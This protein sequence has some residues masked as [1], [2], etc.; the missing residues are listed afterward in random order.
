MTTTY[1]IL[2]KAQHHDIYPKLFKEI[3]GHDDPL[4]AP[5]VIA[6]ALEKETY[7][8][9]VSGYYRSRAIFYIQYS[10]ILPGLRTRGKEVRYFNN[11]LDLIE[12]RVFVTM[13]SNIDVNVM[14]ILLKCGFIPN[15]IEQGSD[16]IL[17][18]NWIRG[19]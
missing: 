10:G 3:F 7:T 19:K 2:S 4:Q 11:C 15:G 16:G 13:I 9:F 14:R 5:T 6:A 18:V 1:K 8:G 17:Y 12:C